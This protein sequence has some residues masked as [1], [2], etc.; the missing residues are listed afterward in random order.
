M[1]PGSPAPCPKSVDSHRLLDDF[2]T[3]SFA[4]EVWLFSWCLR[5]FVLYG[6]CGIFSHLPSP[7][8]E[9]PHPAFGTPLRPSGRGEGE[10]EGIANPRLT[11]WANLC[12]SSGARFC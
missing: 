9:R 4:T 1:K 3:P 8:V 5:V 10:R 7:G 2:R 11:P 12:R 6:S